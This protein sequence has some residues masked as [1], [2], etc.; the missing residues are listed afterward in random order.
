MRL[1]NGLSKKF[2]S[3]KMKS[4]EILSQEEY[5]SKF[6]HGEEYVKREFYDEYISQRLLEEFGMK[7]NEKT[8]KW[9][10]EWSDNRRFLVEL[11]HPKGNHVY[12]RWGYNY[13]FVF[14]INHKNKLTWHRTESS[15]KIHIDDAWYNHMEHVREQEWGYS[16]EEFYNPKKCAVFQYEIPTYTSDMEFALK[17]IRSVI[18]KNIPLMREWLNNVKTVDDAI[19]I[20]NQRIMVSHNVHT[21]SMCHIRAFLYA[22]NGDMENA[23]RSVE[24][25][26][27]EGEG[28][29][30]I[31]DRLNLLANG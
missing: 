10:S 18:D 14:D 3:K 27:A 1:F 21:P 30:I 2:C 19:N 7:Y 6:L 9:Y 20:L 28:Q 11:Y 23:I 8:K 12:L 4:E 31:I 13:D 22:K 5:K 24:Q 15:M 16:K 17:Y 29:Q 26:Y 25:G